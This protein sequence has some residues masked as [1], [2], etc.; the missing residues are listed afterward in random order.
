MRDREAFIREYG[1]AEWHLEL[2]ERV[3][4]RKTMLAW[5]EAVRRERVSAPRGGRPES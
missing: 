5:Y 4:A 3:M 1:E 2:C